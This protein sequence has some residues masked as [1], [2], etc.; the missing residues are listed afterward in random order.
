MV[1]L[2]HL[3]KISLFL[4]LLKISIEIPLM[5]QE[6]KTLSIP[7]ILNSRNV[8]IDELV[9]FLEP[10]SPI[11]KLDI[12]NWPHYNYQ[13][14]V[15]FQISHTNDAIL[16]IYHV[17]EK[18]VLAEKTQTN[19]DTYQDSCVEFFV[20]FDNDPSYYNFE[21]NSIGT[22]HLAYGP[23]IKTRKFIPP[24]LIQKY[25]ETHPSLGRQPIDIKKER[26]SWTLSI[27]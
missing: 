2:S 19:S 14:D 5:S 18:H 12:I 10:L 9:T 21:F 26:T 25:I 23:N 22:I 15:S 27:M 11:H 13:P 16:L 6:N 24:H 8:P 1:C 3:Y 20:A 7:K 4:F 17:T